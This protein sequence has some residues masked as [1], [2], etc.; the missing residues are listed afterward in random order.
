MLVTHFL[1]SESSKERIADDSEKCRY[2]KH[3][4]CSIFQKLWLSD[5]IAEIPILKSAFKNYS[6]SSYRFDGYSNTT[7][8]YRFIFRGHFLLD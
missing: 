6:L 8:D 2:V 1:S 7:A 5:I 3:A 4:Y